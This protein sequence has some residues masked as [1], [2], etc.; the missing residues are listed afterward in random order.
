MNLKATPTLPS[1][2]A[3]EHLCSPDGGCA[4][5]FTKV[6]EVDSCAYRARAQHALLCSD[7]PAAPWM[8]SGRGTEGEGTAVSSACLRADSAHGL[9]LRQ[10]KGRGTPGMDAKLGFMFPES[11]IAGIADVAK[12]E[13]GSELLTPLISMDSA[14]LGRVKL[15]EIS[16]PG[17][18][19]VRLMSHEDMVLLSAAAG[20]EEARVAAHVGRQ[21]RCRFVCERVDAHFELCAVAALRLPEVR[22][23]KVLCETHVLLFWGRYW[24]HG[25]VKVCT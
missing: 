6:T 14:G 12:E 18:S 20:D 19:V 24:L 17:G 4:K 22:S 5:P 10:R 3:Q 9:T 8:P 21:E 16:A 15:M 2:T 7:L 11:W 1:R 25:N 13:F 23:R